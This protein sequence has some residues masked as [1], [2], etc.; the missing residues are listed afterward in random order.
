LA[1]CLNLVIYPKNRTCDLEMLSQTTPP[2]KYLCLAHSLL[3]QF[4]IRVARWFL[5]RPKIPIWVYFGGPWNGKFW[6][7]CIF[8]SFGIFYDHWVYFWAFVNSVVI[9]YIFPHFG[10]LHQEKSGNP[11]PNLSFCLFLQL[12][13]PLTLCQ[14][15]QNGRIFSYWATVYFG[16]LF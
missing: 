7:I 14:G 13:F 9:W 5:F 1:E 12:S 4:T 11:A 6:Y 16:Q 8:W 3:S 2:N 15:D 10:T